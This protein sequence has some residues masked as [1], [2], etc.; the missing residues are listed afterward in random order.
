[1]PL[2]RHMDSIEFPRSGPCTLGHNTHPVGLAPHV[3][4]LQVGGEARVNDPVLTSPAGRTWA[5]IPRTRMHC[6]GSSP[7]A[8]TPVPSYRRQN[9]GSGGAE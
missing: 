8:A 6:P 3:H 4:C 7:G 9:Q 2:P 5:C 1:M